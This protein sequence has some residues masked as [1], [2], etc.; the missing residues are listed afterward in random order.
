MPLIRIGL[1]R[2]GR[3]RQRDTVG[4]ERESPPGTRQ[5]V[6]RH[7]HGPRERLIGE[8]IRRLTPQAAARA[9]EHERQDPAEKLR[10][11]RWFSA[12]N[13]RS[14]MRP[15]SFHSGSS[16]EC[17]CFPPPCHWLPPAS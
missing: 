7:E 9:E 6:Q 5:I 14:P 13:S 8:R 3:A 2:R 16:C 12:I 15:A 10:R 4:N 11:V 1:V 17:Q